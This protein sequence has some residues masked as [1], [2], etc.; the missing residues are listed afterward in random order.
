MVYIVNLIL[1]LILD[2]GMLKDVEDELQRK[3]KVPFLVQFLVK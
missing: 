3:V 1:F 2:Q